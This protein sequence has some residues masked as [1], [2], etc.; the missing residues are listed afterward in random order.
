[1]ATKRKGSSLEL[2]ETRTWNTVGGCT[3]TNFRYHRRP[4]LALR[5]CNSVAAII[6]LST[7]SI[8]LA[9]T[10]VAYTQGQNDTINIAEKNPGQDT[11]QETPGSVA[12]ASNLQE[13]EQAETK[14]HTEAPLACAPA[15]TAIRVRQRSTLASGASLLHA[16]DVGGSTGGAHFER[17]PSDILELITMNQ[18]IGSCK[19]IDTEATSTFVRLKAAY[20]DE[21]LLDEEAHTLALMDME[22]ACPLMHVLTAD[23]RY[24]SLGLCG[25]FYVSGFLFSLF[26]L[27]VSLVSSLFSFLFSFLSSLFSFLHNK[28][29][30]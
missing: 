25:A 7:D 6:L 12:D 11:G 24:V 27:L 19:T 26:S 22:A 17:R 10:R 28:R 9:S 29:N 5:T 21:G 13:S 16:E 20:L 23:L 8:F 2:G 4:V 1:M 14:E 15:S 3:S 30:S 18:G